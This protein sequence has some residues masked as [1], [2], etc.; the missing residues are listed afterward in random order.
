[1]YGAGS[2]GGDG[3]TA[4]A[5]QAAATAINGRR[6][7][8]QPSGHI[9]A[10]TTIGTTA[11]TTAGTTGRTAAALQRVTT[12]AACYPAPD[13]ATLL[14]LHH[15][16]G[17]TTT[18][19]GSR[20][21]LTNDRLADGGDAALGVGVLGRRPRLVW[22]TPR[23]TDGAPGA[24]RESVLDLVPDGV[25]FGLLQVVVVLAVVVLWR[26]RR[27]GRLVA[28]PLPVVVRAG[29]ATRGR[30]RLYRRARAR[31]RA[32][33]VLRAAAVRR[34]ALRCGLARTADPGAVALVVAD[35]TGRSAAD[36]HA[37]LAGS[38]PADDASLVALAEAL[39]ALETEV[40]S[41]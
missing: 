40:R 14:V 11:G 21:P 28:E 20:Q 7:T 37:L 22:W 17:R 39:D 2:A 4:P 16:D 41:S 18:L 33:R 15:P 34:I 19:L 5:D 29:E 36:V 9:I 8:G 6:T 38:E 35:R 31:G 3:G 13:G 12:S 24:A 32:A 26:G 10:G 25:R 30:A 1:V 23:I 27:L